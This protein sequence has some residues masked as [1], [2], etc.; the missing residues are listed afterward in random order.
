MSESEATKRACDNQ[1]QSAASWRSLIVL[2][3]GNQGLLPQEI[4]RETGIPVSTVYR[5]YWIW[6]GKRRAQ[7][8]RHRQ[9]ARLLA[10]TWEQDHTELQQLEQP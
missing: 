5:Y 4:A 7:V 1:C 9:A 10:Q 8:A 6:F 3:L 2:R